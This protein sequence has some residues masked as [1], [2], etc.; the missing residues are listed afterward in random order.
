MHED[1]SSILDT[2]LECWRDI[3]MEMLSRQIDNRFGA[4]KTFLTRDKSLRFL[5]IR[6]IIE[7]VE[8]AVTACKVRLEKST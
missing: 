6:G 1:V 7:A 5:S 2:Y 4:Q 3:K 8:D